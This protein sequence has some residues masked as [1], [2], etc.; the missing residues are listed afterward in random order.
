MGAKKT[1]RVLAIDGGG[2]RGVIPATICKHL[3]TIAGPAMPMWKL[4]DFI[5]GTST[6]G[7]MTMLLTRPD[8]DRP[9]QAKFSAQ[10]CIDLYLQHGKDL[11]SA[12]ANYQNEHL[13]L[14]TFPEASVVPTLQT[15]LPK[16]DCELKQA[17][18]E[19][20]VTAY[21]ITACQPLLFTS[22]FAKQNPADNFYMRDVAQA[23]TAFPGLFPAAAITNVVGDRRLLCVD[24]GMSGASPVLQAYMHASEV[25]RASQS[26]LAAAQKGIDAA[27]SSVGL[28]A[29]QL[30][31][32]FLE[33][34]PDLHVIVVSLGTGHY[35]QPIIPY[36]KAEPWGFA[37]WL[38]FLPDL[39]FDA[40]NH[41]AETEAAA[42]LGLNNYFR[43][44]VD[45]PENLSWTD[46]VENVETL[47]D[48]ADKAMSP[49]GDMYTTF[50]RLQTV[51]MAA[52][53]NAPA[54]S[55][56]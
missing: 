51:L 4:F 11:F 9:N 36:D 33:P 22:F 41:T 19:V 26:I 14:P 50:Q 18:T 6:G 29:P 40:T 27:L 15:F 53:P 12:P 47:H 17:L 16:P 39:M 54:Q 42:L 55:A 28:H 48:V 21:D 1:V 7:L 25:T 3:E 31:L 35:L 24:G 43:F 46:C 45:L 37:Q 34:D 32:L 13:L 56:G 52:Q 2:I 38:K 10:D 30:P 23:T 20:A 49:G 5:V 8:P 44:Q